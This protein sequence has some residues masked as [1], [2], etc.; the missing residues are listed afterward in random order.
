MAEITVAPPGYVEVAYRVEGS[1]CA[2]C[3]GAHRFEGHV[4]D[5]CG[6]IA[7]GAGGVLPTWFPFPGA[8]PCLRVVDVNG[9]HVSFEVNPAQFERYAVK[10]G[11]KFPEW[12]GHAVWIVNPEDLDLADADTSQQLSAVVRE[13]VIENMIDSG[14]EIRS[15][16]D[17]MSVVHVE[18]PRDVL[19]AAVTAAVDEGELIVGYGDDHPY[20]DG[21]SW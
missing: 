9:E 6:S 7:D 15:N 1:T 13:R 10:V 3:E 20:P 5:D 2:S 12:Q 17:R 18:V 19:L 14:V 4:C 8:P 16:D 11:W 21:K